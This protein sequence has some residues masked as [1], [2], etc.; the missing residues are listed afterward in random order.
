MLKIL[1]IGASI[2][3]ITTGAIAQNAEQ[4]NRQVQGEYDSPDPDALAPL[5]LMQEA[6]KDPMA[7]IGPGQKK[8]GYKKIKYA[9]DNLMYFRTRE[10]MYTSVRLPED[11]VIEEIAIGDPDLF[12]VLRRRNNLFL[13][14]PTQP[15]ADH[16]I[17]V[18][19]RTGRIYPFYVSSEGANAS[20]IP[21][22]LVDVVLPKQSIRTSNSPSIQ[23]HGA[24]T[25][26]G[27]PG[28]GSQTLDARTESDWLREVGFRPENVVH[29]L[30]AFAPANANAAGIHPENVFRDDRW[31]YIYYGENAAHMTEWPVANLIVQGVE[32]PVQ[33]DTAGPQG[34]MLIVKAIG[35]IVLR[36]GQKII[37]I[38]LKDTSPIRLRATAAKRPIPGAVVR[39]TRQLAQQT[40][41]PEYWDSTAAP[42]YE[43]IL[44]LGLG[45]P[46]QLNRLWA[47]L[48]VEHFS[49]EPYLRPKFVPASSAPVAIDTP[50]N[51]DLSGLSRL[52][53]GTIDDKKKAIDLCRTLGAAQQSCT[54]LR[55]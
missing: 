52:Q 24:G 26:Y 38:K 14:R 23:T 40:S 29:D 27:T 35:D 47:R 45:E 18:I 50:D 53:L 2:A 3:A 28:R 41:H 13:V 21:D 16:N 46:E 49:Q 42:G 34:R 20:K 33:Q 6:F 43:Y 30:E 32:E 36:N 19:G 51:I 39:Q 44:D 22:I 31:T 4:R 7:N 17:T 48:K 1:M 11:E 54:V 25:Y 9:P 5:G 15:G 12:E 8:P 37:C 10:A 55:K